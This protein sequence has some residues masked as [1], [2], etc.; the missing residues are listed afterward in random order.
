MNL[1]HSD[2]KL[3]A[4]WDAYGTQVQIEL[5]PDAQVVAGETSWQGDLLAG[6]IIEL[7]PTI[8]FHTAGNK[9]IFCRALCNINADNVW[10]DLAEL[11]LKIGGLETLEH[12]AP[13]P[14]TGR[15]ILGEPENP[16]NQSVIERA[17]VFPAPNVKKNEIPHPPSAIPLISAPSSTPEEPVADAPGNL[18]V[19]GRWRFYD[20]DDNPTS[21]QLYVEI[22][23]GDNN[24]HLAWCQTDV[25]G[26]YSCGPFNNPGSAGVKS[27][28]LS[29]AQ[30]APYDDVLVTI[31]PD[32]G[33]TGDAS[34]CIWNDN[35]GANISR[36]NP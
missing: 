36:R 2:V 8:L 29:Y 20:R 7:A 12:Y 21:E 17:P 26:Y 31:N 27:R 19:T 35:S 9:A 4:I 10:G 1:P 25:D 24:D 18:T 13:I 22:V 11:Y 16:D 14:D 30:F 33:T 3:Q 23:R 32:W 6:D 5:P 15:D 28:F 34:K